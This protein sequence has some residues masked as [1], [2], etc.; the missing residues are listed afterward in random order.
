M[1]EQGRRTKLGGDGDEMS[2]EEGASGEQWSCYNHTR[3]R[4]GRG[5]ESAPKRGGTAN[6]RCLNPLKYIFL[7][8]ALALIGRQP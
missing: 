7:L 5:P 6:W 8:L 3:L 2:E 4:G 1:A